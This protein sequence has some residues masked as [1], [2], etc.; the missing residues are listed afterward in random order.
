MNLPSASTTETFCPPQYRTR[1]LTAAILASSLGFVDGTVVSIALPAIRANLPASLV[2]AQW[3]SASYLLMLSAL[4]MAGGA[5]GDRFGIKPVFAGGIALFLIASLLCSF[6][7]S[8]ELLIA[9][10]TLQGIGAAIMV[11]GS[12]AIIAKAYPPALRGQA[13]GVWASF[14][15][16][17]AAL[18]PLA[19]GLILSATGD[20]GW[21]LIFA[22]NLP[23]G[24]VSLGLLQP[25]PADSPSGKARLDIAGVVLATAALGLLSLGLTGGFP[26]MA[27]ENGS[28]PLPELRLV[29]GGFAILALFFWWQTKA[30]SPTLPLGLFRDPTFAGANLATFLLYFALGAMLFFL[31]MTLISAW[32]TG[33]TLAALPFLPIS[34]L[35]GAMSGPVGKRAGKTGPRN[36]MAVGSLVCASGYAFLALTAHLQW[37]WLALMPSMVVIGAGLGLLVS[38]LSIAVMT[39]VPGGQTGVASAVNN[40]VARL[41][42]LMATTS[43]GVVVAMIYSSM[44]GENL[45]G[46]QYG[47]IPS[48]IEDAQALMLFSD[49]SNAALAMV[50]WICTAASLVAAMV[51]WLTL[52]ERS[53]AVPRC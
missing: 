38:P 35:V 53:T 4:L 19:G 37:F 48:G 26:G 36:F 17:T 18:G 34:L 51:S 9:A 44:A 15:A 42:G 46:F 1:V 41:S 2:A 7:P 29:V 40:T 52:G 11:P 6:A 39:G 31:P 27:G 32:N 14:S 8:A 28:A 22:I 16:A 21:R 3:V 30:I 33:P 10:R 45:P 12:L 13:I 47:Q 49:A 50:G 20:W 23:L 25:V 5:L 43:L 24:L